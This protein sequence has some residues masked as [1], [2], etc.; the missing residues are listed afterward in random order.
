MLENERYKFIPKNDWVEWLKQHKGEECVVI[1]DDGTE[2]CGTLSQINYAQL[3][4]VVD[5]ETE[6]FIVKSGWR[7]IKILKK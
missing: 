1:L 2:L 6:H 7:Y 3:N 4:F 5:T